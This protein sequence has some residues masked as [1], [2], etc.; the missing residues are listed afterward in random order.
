MTLEVSAVLIGQP[1]TSFSAP[2]AHRL[3]LCWR[4]TKFEVGVPL[5]EGGGGGGGGAVVEKAEEE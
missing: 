2:S 3:L 1:S 4:N 5:V